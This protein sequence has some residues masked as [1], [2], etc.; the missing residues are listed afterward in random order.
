MAKDV[1]QAGAFSVLHALARRH[2][3]RAPHLLAVT[4]LVNESAVSAQVKAC[5]HLHVPTAQHPRAFFVQG[6]NLALL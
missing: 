5:A 6:N 4:K 2:P 1:S 3:E